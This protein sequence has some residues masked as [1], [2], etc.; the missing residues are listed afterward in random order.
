[1]GEFFQHQKW[2]QSIHE[3]GYD[4]DN[5]DDRHIASFDVEDH[6][7]DCDDDNHDDSDDHFIFNHNGGDRQYGHHDGDNDN[8][9]CQMYNNYW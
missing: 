9:T 1:M 8:G 5:N 3:A 2:L 4:S 7:S 6:D